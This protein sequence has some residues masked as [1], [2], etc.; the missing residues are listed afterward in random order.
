MYSTVWLL[1]M[2][3]GAFLICRFLQ[4]WNVFRS[5]FDESTVVSP[6]QGLEYGFM[7]AARN[8]DL[9]KL[10]EFIEQGCSVTAQDKVSHI[11]GVTFQHILFF[12]RQGMF[13]CTCTTLY[14][15]LMCSDA[16]HSACYPST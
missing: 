11:G 4:H 10:E 16:P 5:A 12:V 6:V 2:Y 7:V 3:N 1:S 15:L 13:P 14:L 9:H 8:G